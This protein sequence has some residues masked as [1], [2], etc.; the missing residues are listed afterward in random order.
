MKCTKCGHKYK[1]APLISKHQC[2]IC[3]HFDDKPNSS[4]ESFEE[5]RRRDFDDIEI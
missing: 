4:E 5:Q 1:E 2:P 3:G